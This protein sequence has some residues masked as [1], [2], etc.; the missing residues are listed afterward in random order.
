MSVFSALMLM[1]TF[2]KLLIDVL[3]YINSNRK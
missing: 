2:A 3:K 1:L